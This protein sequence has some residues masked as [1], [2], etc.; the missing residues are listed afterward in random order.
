MTGPPLLIQEV[1]ASKEGRDKGGGTSKQLQERQEHRRA[2]TIIL[3]PQFCIYLP[4][5]CLSVVSPVRT[6]GSYNTGCVLIYVYD[7]VSLGIECFLEGNI[8]GSNRFPNC[9]E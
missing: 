9:E 5:F 3:I 6:W 4:F 8:S 7:S 2:P 1:G